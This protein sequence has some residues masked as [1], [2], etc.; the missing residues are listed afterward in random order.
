MG[1]VT[2]CFLAILALSL[3]ACTTGQQATLLTGGALAAE[4]KAADHILQSGEVERA[5]FS[6]DLSQDA[7][8]E[9]EAG[10]EQYELSR[11]ILGELA[12]NPAELGSAIT[13]IK[14]ERTRLRSA[15][16]RIQAVVAANWADYGEF[17][18]SKLQ[19]WEIQAKRLDTRYN[20]F[21]EAINSE[22][23]SDAR[24]ILAVE[25]LRIV[26]QIAL[27]AL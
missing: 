26:A 8:A 14:D 15:Y 11:S 24:Y 9:V 19:R 23:S 12:K 1:K 4:T 7:R 3:A 27:V 18:K 16:H 22:L 2:T 13:T 17:E 10:F 6:A 21:A 20:A 25:L 5:V